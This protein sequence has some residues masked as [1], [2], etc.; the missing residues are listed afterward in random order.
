MVRPACPNPET[1]APSGRRVSVLLSLSNSH[2]F[3]QGREPEPIDRHHR[4]FFLAFPQDAGEP[5]AQAHAR[6]VKL[7]GA[8]QGRSPEEDP[9]AKAA[10]VQEPILYRSFWNH[11]ES[12]MAI[13]VVA[14]RPFMPLPANP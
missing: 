1:A 13:P 3:W 7:V 10:E 9:L 12:R 6:L 11:G 2:L 8:A 4:P 14:R 5:I